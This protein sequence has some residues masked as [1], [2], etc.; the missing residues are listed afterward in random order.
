MRAVNPQAIIQ[1]TTQHESHGQTQTHHKICPL[2]AFN[3][4]FTPRFQKLSFLNSQLKRPVGPMTLRTYGRTN[5]GRL[6]WR[7]RL[8]TS[9]RSF[10]QDALLHRYAKAE[11]PT[12][13][14]GKQWG[15]SEKPCEPDQPRPL[16]L[17]EPQR[18]AG[19]QDLRFPRW[20][21]PDEGGGV[22]RPHR[23]WG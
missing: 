5:S 8:T 13:Q 11:V 9:E 19:N 16:E 18:D 14:H 22:P 21:D 20:A 23:L 10:T 1:T 7:K 6:F 3:F 2:Q 15:T 17:S 4:S 12:V